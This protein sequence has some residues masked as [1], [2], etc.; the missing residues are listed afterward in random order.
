MLFTSHFFM[1]MFGGSLEPLFRTKRP[2]NNAAGK[3]WGGGAAP[4][5]EG[6]TPGPAVPAA[7]PHRGSCHRA[8][9]APSP[10][11]EA[12]AAVGAGRREGCPLPSLPFLS[13]GP[14][15]R[16]DQALSSAA[17]APA[18]G[19]VTPPCQREAPPTEMLPH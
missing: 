14:A 11:G 19:P 9:P 6:G 16:E 7:Q 3:H 17:R 15:P 12:S 18:P 13:T 2:G 10:A 1:F 8:L 4:S 5:G